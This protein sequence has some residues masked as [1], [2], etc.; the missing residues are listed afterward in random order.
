MEECGG[1]GLARGD[2]IVSPLHG[3]FIVN[4]GRATAREV[5]ALMDAVRDLVAQKS[6]VRL[7]FE[8]QRWRAGD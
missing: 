7:D 5:F 3:N 6:G 8:V 1:K 2:A 4:R